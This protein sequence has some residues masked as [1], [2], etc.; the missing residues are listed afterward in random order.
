MSVDAEGR[1]QNAA[2][3]NSVH[4]NNEIKNAHNWDSKPTLMQQ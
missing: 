2:T 1:V 4:L 3:C